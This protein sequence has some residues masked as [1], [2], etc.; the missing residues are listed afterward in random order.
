[1]ITKTLHNAKLGPSEAIPL[2][3]KPSQSMLRL[4][5]LKRVFNDAM[6]YLSSRG[7]PD[8]RRAHGG[9]FDRQ[10]CQAKTSVASVRATIAYLGK[11]GNTK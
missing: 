4:I 7:G 2:K 1:M 10:E 8:E 3:R 6:S 9:H 5:V 11:D